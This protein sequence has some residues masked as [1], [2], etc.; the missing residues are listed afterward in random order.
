MPPDAN[1][2]HQEG[3]EWPSGRHRVATKEAPSSHQGGGTFG[4][5]G[6]TEWPS[7]HLAH[8]RPVGKVRA[9]DREVE[10]M[11]ALEQRVV[12]CVQEPRRVRHLLHR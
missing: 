3:T 5:Q 2:G 8:K 9:T 7:A 11:Y 1:R 4:Q 12:K 10:Y 6:G